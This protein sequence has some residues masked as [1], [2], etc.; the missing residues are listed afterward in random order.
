MLENL[1]NDLKSL[2]YKEIDVKE[3]LEVDL[4]TTLSKVETDIKSINK[5][6]KKSIMSMEILKEDMDKK[7]YVKR[8][9]T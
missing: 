5:N 1:I 3:E 6:S 8:T 7:I 9:G 2:E 4:F